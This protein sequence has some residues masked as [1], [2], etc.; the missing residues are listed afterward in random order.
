[1]WTLNDFYRSREWEAFRE[2]VIAERVREDGL[3]YDEI[4]GEPIVRKYDI[5]LHHKTHLTEENVNDR[6]ISLNPDN[7]QI[8]S[9]RTHNRIH[10]KLGYSRKEIF[11]VYGPPLAGKTTYVDSVK[12]P[13]DLIIDMDSI[14]QSISGMPRYQKPA[15]LK[16]VAFGVRDYLLDALKVRNGKW[17]T[18][19]IIQTMSLPNER[20][21]IAREYGARLIHIDT[22]RETCL[23]RLERAED[24]RNKDE[25]KQYIEEY[26]RRNELYGVSSSVSE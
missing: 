16:S 19:Y 4:T 18:A 22:D 8:V 26:F 12:V 11:L 17:M 7:I 25:W 23:E 10:E 9:H 5:I 1:M 6:S 13:G 3:I 20:E 21:R 14:W 24:G 2:V 15:R